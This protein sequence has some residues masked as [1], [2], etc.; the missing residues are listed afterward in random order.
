MGGGAGSVTLAVAAGTAAAVGYAAGYLTSG[1]SG[2]GSAGSAG[3][4][5]G[6]LAGNGAPPNR[7]LPLKKKKAKAEGAGEGDVKKGAALF[8]AKCATC[9]SCIEGGP[10]KQGPNL[11]GIIGQQAAVRCH[12]GAAR[13]CIAPCMRPCRRSRPYAQPTIASELA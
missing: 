6:E 10:T 11:Y 4:A 8:K 9:H 3:S 5:K 2:Q 13:A 12:A 1:S 7:L